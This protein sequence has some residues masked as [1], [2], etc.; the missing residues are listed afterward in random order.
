MITDKETAMPENA[1]PSI[2]DDYLAWKGRQIE[3][4]ELRGQQWAA[5]ALYGEDSPQA[6]TLGDG[7]DAL[8]DQSTWPESWRRLTAEVADDVVAHHEVL[9]HSYTAYSAAILDSEQHR[10]QRTRPTFAQLQAARARAG[11][12]T[13]QATTSAHR[14]QRAAG[15][16]FRAVRPPSAAEPVAPTRPRTR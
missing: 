1:L 14:Q 15:A 12:P 3:I 16:T 8:S 9:S 11:A 5:W 4:A 13:S 10:T 2:D 6:T 7:I